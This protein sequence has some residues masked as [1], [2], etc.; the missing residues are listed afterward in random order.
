MPT[1]SSIYTPVDIESI[2]AKLQKLSS[3]NKRQN[4]IWKPPVGESTVRIVPYRHAKDPF[5]ELFFHYDVGNRTALCAANFA[6]QCPICDFAQELR[7][8]KTEEDFQIFKKIA[9]KTRVYVPVLVRGKED[10][11]IKFWGI[12]KEVYETLLNLYPN[13]EY[14]DITHPVDGVDITVRFT[15]PTATLKFGKVDVTPKRN[16]SQLHPD[17]AMIVKIIKEVP[18]IFEVFPEQSF[19]ELKQILDNFLN[20]QEE[21]KDSKTESLGEIVGK[22][23]ETTPVTSLVDKEFEELFKTTDKS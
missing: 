21:Q 18:N 17:K 2:K 12:G 10:D 15:G 1:Q 23:S 19:A 6:K 20:P 7:K 16:S 22:T 13:P 8:K 9:A 4:S 11:G 14:G 5:N 3:T